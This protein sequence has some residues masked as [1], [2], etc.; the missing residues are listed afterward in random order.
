MINA[1]LVW[2]F[3][4]GVLAAVL[5]GFL[6][7][8]RLVRW[9]G[10]GAAFSLAGLALILPVGRPIRLFLI[11]GEISPVFSAVGRRLILENDDRGLIFLVF[12]IY[13]VWNLITEHRYMSIRVVPLGMMGAGLT[14]A[15]LAVEPLFYGAV[16]LAFLALLYILVLT[17]PPK[18][19]TQ[20]V[21]RF[22][23]YQVLGTMLILF[24]AW[25]FSWVD[26]SAVDQ[27]LLIRALII[28]GV[29]FTFLLAVFPF[30][31]WIFMLAEENHPFLTAFVLNTY[32]TGV[33]LFGFRFLSSAGWLAEL[34]DIQG[35]IR[36]AGVLMMLL[37]GFSAFFSNH[38]GKILGFSV[39]VEIGRSLLAVS[40][41]QEGFPLFL[42]LVIVQTL[43][44]SVWALSLTMLASVSENLNYS[45]L[46][47][48]ARQWP[49]LFLGS[50]VG[51]FT[52]AGLPLL[53]G[54]PPV[55]T[56]AE[57]LRTISPF[58]AGSVLIASAGLL[59]GAF[60]SAV[61]LLGS[62]GGEDVLV[63]STRYT[64]SVIAVG[65][66][67]SAVL[68]L[69]SGILDPVLAYLSGVFLP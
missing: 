6:N 69:V 47:G 54:F 35:V 23:I 51:Q 17:P 50:C 11:T 66:L 20:G 25:M 53:A 27:V 45:S 8:P 33:L 10:T 4:P 52:L 24:A 21:L 32:L 34:I 64:R 46:V 14:L 59:A 22:L 61:F 65:L 60:R 67:V 41:L 57:S 37:G 43:A 2:I 7:Y 5:L 30:S 1:P 62:A 42:H 12:V 29:G 18:P 68:G 26:L 38:L 39:T 15:A 44:L 56:L 19:A 49:I 31:S 16:F 3:F 63:V 28:L 9:I 58:A 55:W 40:L 48:A 36:S 13:G